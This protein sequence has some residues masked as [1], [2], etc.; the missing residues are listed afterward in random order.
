MR[1]LIFFLFFLNGVPNMTEENLKTFDE[2]AK[3]SVSKKYSTEKTESKRPGKGKLYF[4]D[5]NVM[6]L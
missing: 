3:R 1:I 2:F 6:F 5:Y 4:D